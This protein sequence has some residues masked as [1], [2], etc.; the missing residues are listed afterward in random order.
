MKIKYIGNFSDGTGWAKASTYNALAL[1]S[2]GHDV[3]CEE[4][5]YNKA[6]VF[7]EEE[8]KNLLAKQTDSFDMVVHHIL[9]KDYRYVPGVINVGCVELENEHFSNVVWL[10]RLN[11]MD[12]IWVPNKGSKRCLES[13]GINSSK[14]KVFNHTFN[15]EKIINLKSIASVAQLKNSFNFVFVGEFVKRKNIEALLIAFHNEFDR[16]E[17]VNLYIKTN[18]NAPSVTQHCDEVKNRMKKSNQ[19]KKDVIVTDYMPEEVL[20]STIQQCHA[21]VMPSYGEAWCYPAIEAMAL[22]VPPIYTSGI[23]IEDYASQVGFAVKSRETP[24][25]GAIDTLED[26]YTSE[27]SWLEIDIFDLQRKMREVYELFQQDKAGYDRLRNSC[28]KEVE[29]FNFTN[30]KIVEDLV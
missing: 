24:C 12:M 5:K 8:I 16:V 4:V 27:D 18:G 21:F 15:Y 30:N 26:L 29:K 3:Y 9:P 20:L 13:S 2:A 23:G 25:Y 6:E 1:S 10:K 14:I 11:T 19:Y 17:P 28:I 7:L 22:G